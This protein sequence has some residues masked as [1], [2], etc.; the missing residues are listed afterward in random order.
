M[1]PKLVGKLTDWNPAAEL[2]AMVG[3]ELETVVFADPK[4]SEV[5]KSLHDLNEVIGTPYGDRVLYE[6][7]QNAHDAHKVGENGGKVMIFLPSEPI[8]TGNNQS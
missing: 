8:N 6:L 1:G 7:I 5:Y 3:S 4:G 2:E